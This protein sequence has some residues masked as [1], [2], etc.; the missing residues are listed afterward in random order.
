M[1][2]FK[3]LQT[4]RLLTQNNSRINVQ[5]LSRLWA[6]DLSKL[7]PPSITTLNLAIKNTS[8]TASSM[9][10]LRA[11]L[12]PSEESHK[13]AKPHFYVLANTLNGPKYLMQLSALCKAFQVEEVASDSDEE[14]T[15]C[16]RM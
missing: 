5:A 7:D 14:E 10:V 2:L 12:S 6:E 1:S 15:T 8:R 11:I 4:L 16:L 9:L 3:A 13:W